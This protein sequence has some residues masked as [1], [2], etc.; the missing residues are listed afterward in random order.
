MNSAKRGPTGIVVVA[1]KCGKVKFRR[2]GGIGPLPPLLPIS[3]V[4]PLEMQSILPS[5]TEPSNTG[6]VEGMFVFPRDVCHYIV[7]F[8]DV[9][10]VPMFA[11]AIRQL[12]WVTFVQG[13]YPF[14][15]VA[16]HRYRC[17]A[18]YI[19]RGSITGF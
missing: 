4:F 19:L 5:D 9:L 16:S 10:R 12:L 14:N 6:A 2:A 15:P 13:V 8:H 3:S 11:M 1:K 18:A 7:H 17:Y